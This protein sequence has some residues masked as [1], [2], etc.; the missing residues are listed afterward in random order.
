MTTQK[1]ASVKTEQGSGRRELRVFIR[2]TVSFH[3]NGKKL[4]THVEQSWTMVEQ[5]GTMMYGVMEFSAS[6]N[7]PLLEPLVEIRGEAPVHEPPERPRFASR[8]AVRGLLAADRRNGD[9]LRIGKGVQD[10]GGAHL[11]QSREETMS[12]CCR[13]S[14]QANEIMMDLDA[15]GQ[16]CIRLPDVNVEQEDS[17]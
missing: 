6:A 11:H 5:H 13:K 9:V 1:N 7:S 14:H 10:Y 12:R 2:I 15:Q 16:A 17:T 8:Q 4:S 3:V